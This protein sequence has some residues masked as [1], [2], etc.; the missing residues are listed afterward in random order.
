[1][2]TTRS[3]L[4][5]LAGL[6]ALPVLTVAVAAA[7]ALGDGPAGAPSGPPSAPIVTIHDGAVQGL[8]VP[9]GF[10][11]RGLPYAAPPI[12]DLRWRPPQRPAS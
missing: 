11:F 1:M 8:A 10:A 5:P 7:S 9:G 3:R 4:L 12:G 6:C 2:H